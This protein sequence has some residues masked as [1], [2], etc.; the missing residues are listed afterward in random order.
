MALLNEAWHTL[1][2]PGRRAVYDASLRPRASAYRRFDAPIEDDDDRES[3]FIAHHFTQPRRWPAVALMLMAA[4]AA[5]F[6][7]TAYAV[8]AGSGSVATESTRP[9]AIGRCVSIRGGVAVEAPCNRPHFGVVQAVMPRGAKCILGT[10]GYFDRNTDDMV[11]VH[12]G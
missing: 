9:L 2:D 5:I 6:V 10:E 1:S 7:F 4:M 8:S 12:V 11:C 3:A